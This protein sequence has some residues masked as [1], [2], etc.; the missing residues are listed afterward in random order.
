MLDTPPHYAIETQLSF[1]RGDDW[2]QLFALGAEETPMDLTGFTIECQA[3]R[4][5]TTITIGIE[6]T[7]L[8]VGQFALT[9]DKDV[10]ETMLGKY[11]YDVQ[12]TDLSDFTLTRITGVINV[13]PDITTP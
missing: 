8:S 10:T 11:N 6:E 1:F 13:A 2:R 7:D 4:G 12:L 9:L 3:K 5:A